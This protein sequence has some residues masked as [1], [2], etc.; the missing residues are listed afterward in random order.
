[1]ENPIIN[2]A[3][4][5]KAGLEHGTGLDVVKQA[6]DR[7]AGPQGGYFGQFTTK[8]IQEAEQ[9]G[10]L[11]CTATFGC[12]VYEKLDAVISGDLSGNWVEVPFVR[13]SELSDYID[14]YLSTHMPAVEGYLPLSGGDMSGDITFQSNNSLFWGDENYH[15]AYIMGGSMGLAVYNDADEQWRFKSSSLPESD[16]DVMR[17]KDLSAVD[18]PTKVSELSNDVGYITSAQVEPAELTYGNYLSGYALKAWYSN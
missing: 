17:R 2:R 14:D 18:V 1:M 13:T 7:L 11:V 12:T 15:D 16:D 9:G 8:R 10:L 6:S 4:L 3:R 5:K